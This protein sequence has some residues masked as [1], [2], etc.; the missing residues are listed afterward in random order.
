MSLTES[1]SSVPKRRPPI[2]PHHISDPPS[3][4][5]ELDQN[6]PEPVAGT[7]YLPEPH[8]SEQE[9]TAPDS[10]PIPEKTRELLNQTSSGR[11]ISFENTGQEPPEI[12]KSTTAPQTILSERT[13]KEELPR[14]WLDTLLPWRWGGQKT[15]QERKVAKPERSGIKNWTVFFIV[16]QF[17]EKFIKG[18]STSDLTGTLQTLSACYHRTRNNSAEELKPIRLKQLYLPG[19]DIT[20]QDVCITP[21]S[22]TPAGAGKGADR[23]TL[24]DIK[25]DVSGQVTVWIDDTKSQQATLD[26]KDVDISAHFKKGTMV[27]KLL[28]KGTLYGNLTY[29]LWN[30]DQMSDCL[31]PTRCTCH[32]NEGATIDVKT[33]GYNDAT[34][35]LKI[36]S[37]DLDLDFAPTISRQGKKA[38]FVSRI[39]NLDTEVRSSR[40]GLIVPDRIKPLMEQLFPHALMGDTRI[41]VK[42]ETVDTHKREDGTLRTDCQNVTLNSKGDIGLRDARIPTLTLVKGPAEP[43]KTLSETTETTLAIHCPT[44]NGH[45][46]I[47]Q[48]T[49]NLPYDIKGQVNLQNTTVTLT[50]SQ[51]GDAPKTLDTVDFSIEKGGGDL[52][53]GIKSTATLIKGINGMLD[54]ES[55]EATVCIQ[56]AVTENITIG[57]TPDRVTTDNMLLTGE[58]ELGKTEIHTKPDS[59][60]GT[61]VATVSV[62]K[63][64]GKRIQGIANAR[65]AQMN[66]L[67]VRF[68][69]GTPLPLQ[70]DDNPEPH[71]VHPKLTVTSKNLT[72][73]N[74]VVPEKITGQG[75]R[76][77]LNSREIKNL[78]I[79]CTMPRT[80]TDSEDQ[81]KFKTSIAREVAP[82]QVPQTRVA[83]VNTQLTTERMDGDVNVAVPGDNNANFETP[84][85]DVGEDDGPALIPRST[86][87]LTTGP[88]Q[89]KLEYDMRTGF[90]TATLESKSQAVIDMQHGDLKGKIVSV[91][92]EA[93]VKGGSKDDPDEITTHTKLDHLTCTGLTASERLLPQGVKFKS[94]V[95]I[96]APAL[97]VTT[98][99]PEKHVDPETGSV[100]LSSRPVQSTIDI[101]RSEWKTH[102]EVDKKKIFPPAL[103]EKFKALT[104]YLPEQYQEPARPLLA[105]LE[106]IPEEISEDTPEA[107]TIKQNVTF[108]SGK[109]TLKGEQ[110]TNSDKTLNLATSY[111]ALDLPSGAVSG[112]AQLGDMT[113]NTSS[114]PRHN[115]LQLDIGEVAIIGVETKD[116]SQLPVQLKT[117]ENNYLKGVKVTV[118]QNGDEVSSRSA[119]RKGNLNLDMGVS[120]VITD[121]DT[122][123]KRTMRSATVKAQVKRVEVNLQQDKHLMIAN[124][125]VGEASLKVLSTRDQ[126]G[127]HLITST[128]LQDT[129][130]VANSAETSSYMDAE[131][132]HL[133]FQVSGELNG[134]VQAHKTGISVCRDM[135]GT[136]INPRLDTRRMKT[137]F[138][139]ASR[140][141]VNIFR[142]S[143]LQKSALGQICDLKVSPDLDEN[144][145]GTLTI[146]AGGALSPVIA[147]ALSRIGGRFETIARPVAQVI[148]KVLRFHIFLDH[149]PVQEGKATMSDLF[150]CLKITFSSDHGRA[151][152]LYA[153]AVRKVVSLT[154][155]F[156]VGSL[157]KRFHMLDS[158]TGEISLTNLTSYVG[159]QVQLV[160][161]DHMPVAFL[162]GTG[163]GLNDT[164]NILQLNNTLPEYWTTDVYQQTLEQRMRAMRWGNLPLE[165]CTEANIPE[166]AQLFATNLPLPK[167]MM[168]FHN[169]ENMLD[170]MQEILWETDSLPST[171]SAFMNRISGGAP[172]MPMDLMVTE[173]IA[174]S[175]T[176]ARIVPHSQQRSSLYKN[177][178]PGVIANELERIEQE[179]PRWITGRGDKEVERPR[180]VFQKAHRE[181]KK[182]M[183]SWEWKEAKKLVDELQHPIEPQKYKLKLHHLWLACKT[184]NKHINT[185]CK[186]IS[187]HG[188][189]KMIISPTGRTPKFEDS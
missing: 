26:I 145:S 175:H 164:R 159:E 4:P 90:D 3:P 128:R 189:L 92:F 130:I 106:S 79:E 20:L 58:F 17:V 97:Q 152:Q 46:N 85:F 141:L 178:E 35:G 8:P 64:D 54:V 7:K 113:V 34:S 47:P 104:I 180:K 62:E 103:V 21:K 59:E 67:K 13:V 174:P 71:P 42:A 19:P 134:N 188:A 31:Q 142:S 89:M 98:Q 144:I 49:F 5:Q 109:T 132:G 44:V 41:R 70:P 23:F 18:L 43:G 185:I 45:V 24:L 136:K 40:M 52:L 15:T 27:E 129:L 156:L 25:A 123:Q 171:S 96:I 172:S 39:K 118:S 126:L 82:W 80:L 148:S 162:P 50:T 99:P 37:A 77:K 131:L 114:S 120:G 48:S 182:L 110:K 53:G 138:P 153:K 169:V 170:T 158:T 163:D 93:Q 9:N 38:T 125:A 179:L 139:Q 87:T 12:E 135:E 140:E 91:G 146:S 107:G 81:A 155:T 108:R 86:G 119:I 143:K 161:K 160:S 60:T 76:A 121:Q 65:T 74:V 73:Q 116:D 95:D 168:E 75:L 88:A 151:G 100:T 63:L 56:K 133:S 165:N 137:S 157:L 72:A 66:N 61:T 166:L 150:S 124:G 84:L 149:L 36:H 30:Y 51:H 28:E 105:K 112:T 101:E 22:V 16:K 1:G 69:T 83:K 176:Y 154:Q 94:D 57:T 115:D 184:I 6:V 117:H 127:T 181:A 122:S 55:K 68:Q 32:L 2:P 10:P 29:A 33:P 177:F 78:T 11:T 187:P 186:P 102:L 147:L 183:E 167:T 14:G 173:T 111:S